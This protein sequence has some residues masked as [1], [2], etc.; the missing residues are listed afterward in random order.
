[1]KKNLIRRPLL[2]LIILGSLSSCRTEDEL[3]Q[4]NQQ[5]DNKF[6]AF[7]SRNGEP[8]N[9]PQGYKNL[10]EKYDSI[11]TTEYTQK[12]ILK[13]R[14]LGKSNS[15]EYVELNIR[16]QELMMKNSERWIL[17]PVVNGSEVLG[18]EV[19][20]LKNEETQLEFWR[21]DPKDDYYKEIIDLYR[22]AYTKK[23]LAEQ[24]MSKGGG[25]CGRP[26]EEPCDTGEVI[27]IVHGPNGPKA[28][29][30]LILPGANPGS[31]DPG[32]IGGDCGVYGNCGGGGTGPNQNNENEDDPCEE[33][34]K[35]NVNTA[36][37]EKIDALD[38]SSVLNQ[39]KETG[40]AESKSGVFTPLSQSAST[41]T[42]DGLTINIT[43]DTKG[44]LHTHL[45]DYE[46]GA[47]NDNGEILTR[48]PIRMFSPADVNT[49]MT[50][51]GF[52]TDGNYSDL[53]GT[54]V[55]SY[56]NYTIKFTGTSADIKTGFD[57][58]KWQTDYRNYKIKN[59][60]WSFEK[61]FLKFLRDEMNVH[62][63]GLYK[64]KSNGTIQRKTLNSDDKIDSTDCPKN[65]K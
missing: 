19:G 1:M 16:S 15:Q 56:G 36:Y 9:Y 48:Q 25:N 4:S 17:Y 33:L 59:N 55:S 58:E 46:T 64:I 40:Y 31:G 21:L 30:N 34:K 63:V 7:T 65:N 23:I 42:S 47:T 62:G 37:K 10:L 35:Q 5:P 45:N 27:I 53:Y 41:D 50:M 12:A 2:L 38:K 8:V 13:N 26:G 39:K 18:I 43:S 24:M 6:Q 32:V 52:V 44:Y 3:I 60:S 54:M 61:L 11:Y 29:P 49:L 14:T 20:I 51:A 57:E 22:S 28:N